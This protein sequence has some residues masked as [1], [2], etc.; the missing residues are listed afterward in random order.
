M[1]YV[2][3]TYSVVFLYVCYSLFYTYVIRMPFV[4]IDPRLKRRRLYVTLSPSALDKL[5]KLS[6]SQDL[7]K[8]RIIED[9]IEGSARKVVNS[10]KPIV[11]V[12]E[13]VEVPIVEELHPGKCS[14]CGFEIALGTP[15]CPNCGVKLPDRPDKLDSMI[16][17]LRRDKERF[18]KLLKTQ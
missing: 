17:R 18:D 10:V 9:L 8:S 16:D 7:P 14:N 13:A 15:Y 1:P 4:K 6:K 12:E 5:D 3:N 11:E 2:F